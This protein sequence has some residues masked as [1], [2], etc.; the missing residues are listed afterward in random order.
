MYNMNIPLIITILLFLFYQHYVCST[1]KPYEIDKRDLLKIYE[2]YKNLELSKE[3]VLDNEES[4]HNIKY[5]S[6][7]NINNKNSIS[8]ISN[9]LCKNI[10]FGYHIKIKGVDLL[11]G[12]IVH[13]GTSKFIKE[14]NFICK[15]YIYD[16]SYEIIK[17]NYVIK[18]DEHY[19]FYLGFDMEHI[20]E[21]KYKIDK[22]QNNNRNN[23]N[24]NDNN[25]NNNNF[26]QS[27]NLQN[28]NMHSLKEQEQIV[29]NNVTYNENMKI[30]NNTKNMSRN[31]NDDN[32]H[33]IFYQND[34]LN[35]Y[36][37][38]N[39]KMC[40]LRI[41]I[42]SYITNVEETL[43]KILIG[44]CI[45]LGYKRF[46]IYSENTFVIS[47]Y[48]EN[49]Y[50]SRDIFHQGFN[51]TCRKFYNSNNI[52]IIK[53]QN[54]FIQNKS[55]HNYRSNNNIDVVRKEVP[56]IYVKFFAN[57]SYLLWRGIE[58]NKEIFNFKLLELKNLLKK[59]KYKER[60]YICY[61][62]ELYSYYEQDEIYIKN[63]MSS[64]KIKYRNFRSLQNKDKKNLDIPYSYILLTFEYFCDHTI[65][66]F[67]ECV[68]I[69]MTSKILDE[70][71]KSIMHQF[72]YESFL[73]SQNC[74]YEDDQLNIFH[75]DMIISTFQKFINNSNSIIDKMKK[76]SISI[77][78]Q[79]KK[80]EEFY[81]NILL[82][83][84]E[85]IYKEFYENIMFSIEFKSFIPLIKDELDKLSRRKNIRND[86][87]NSNNSNNRNNRIC[88]ILKFIKYHERLYESNSHNSIYSRLLNESI[89]LNKLVF[90]NH[91]GDHHFDDISIIN[92][93]NNIKLNKENIN[94]KTNNVEENIKTNEENINT[95]TNNV[96]ENIK[97]NEENINTKTNN[98][99]DNIKTNEENINT[100]TNNVEENIKT[101]KENINIKGNNV[102]ESIKIVYNKNV[103]NNKAQGNEN[104]EH[105]NKKEIIYIMNDPIQSNTTY[106]SESYESI[107]NNLDE[108]NLNN[109]TY[110]DDEKYDTEQINTFT[111]KY[112]KMMNMKI[113]KKNKII[114]N[115]ELELKNNNK[116][117]MHH[118]FIINSYGVYIYT[119]QK[120]Y[121]YDILKKIYDEYKKTQDN[122]NNSNNNNDHMKRKEFFNL[123]YSINKTYTFTVNNVPTKIY[124]ILNKTNII[125][126]DKK[127]DNKEHHSN[128]YE[129]GKKN[130]KYFCSKEKR[131]PFS[132]K[133][134]DFF[135]SDDA[136]YCEAQYVNEFLITVNYGEQTFDYMI[137]DIYQK[138]DM[139]KDQNIYQKGD[140]FKDQ[141]IYQKGD[142]F[143]DQNIHRKDDDY[144][145]NED[146]HSNSHSDKNSNINFIFPEKILHKV[147]E[148]YFVKHSI[149]ESK[150]I[151]FYLLNNA[152]VIK[153]IGNKK[154]DINNPFL[155]N[156]LLK[157]VL[158]FCILHGFTKLKVEAE[159]INYE[160][161]IKNKFVE[162][163][164]NGYT[165]YEY[166]GLT[167]M[168]VARFSK[169][170]YYI[171]TGYTSKSDLL[172]SAVM[173]FEKNFNIY[174]NIENNFL[175]YMNKKS[176]NLL[177]ELTFNCNDDY[178]PYKNCYDLYPLVRKNIK[179]IC[180]F[181][182]NSIYK[183]LNLLFPDVCKIGKKIALCYEQIKKYIVCSKNSQGCK[184]YKFII[185][186][187][188]KPRRK[189]SFFINHNINVQEYLSKKAYTYY[190]LLCELIK[191]KEKQLKQEEGQ[192]KNQNV[193]HAHTYFLLNNIIQYSTFFL[194]WNFSTEFWKRFQYIHNNDIHNINE[195]SYQ[196]NNL[197]FCP[198]AY[199]YEFIYHLNVFYINE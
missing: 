144:E 24:N 175:K 16:N 8:G 110:D 195:I 3:V 185:N 158:G 129:W 14:I 170:L 192:N 28:N 187:F 40:N 37:S 36:N 130:V 108:S 64:H 151:G 98:V 160:S 165:E 101:N 48:F 31:N 50:I 193:D 88:N 13:F 82:P 70:K 105:T 63:F 161:G 184:Y 120:Q 117:T 113:D 191:N 35:Y 198:M 93:K 49:M 111:K 128:M 43:L 171:I 119:L 25:N 112:P 26:I 139:F 78:D 173:K 159:S 95:K 15:Y 21:P 44:L 23:N 47:S 22:N 164:L 79:I 72:L 156:V 179:N 7:C 32:N 134:I 42:Y 155:S 73:C 54:S 41:P 114:N 137:N 45:K 152:C 17:C 103:E 100:K 1:I 176:M 146:I 135:T 67:E 27:N 18:L 81:N 66:L 190:L 163:L 182:T 89:L 39:V 186:T 74:S 167:L 196:N 125:S 177:H 86:S 33:N 197:L 199:A 131:W 124:D 141:N 52:Y 154:N 104:F 62:K 91:K 118:S 84:D 58:Q 12:E 90:E 71:Y 9:I 102:E 157:S 34:Y 11:Y 65:I 69:I 61:T 38:H 140:M 162:I 169:D 148:E 59:V 126:K 2:D 168:N 55:N 145:K 4:F 94:T 106:N 142:M 99:E 138:G 20:Y 87:N 132:K 115:N 56:K 51:I 96:E 85:N 149:N 97:T 5:L 29:L 178:Y 194:F 174:H 147:K 68:H 183:E 107:S 133:E 6:L 121:D 46:M 57:K 76:Q 188:I 30:D 136:I 123:L 180:N 19:D 122:T 143:K 116:G 80:K 53:S 83:Q 172:L 150:I 189:T 166:L 60:I 181:E 153:Y 109:Y 10:N 127:K 75:N 92:L 77:T